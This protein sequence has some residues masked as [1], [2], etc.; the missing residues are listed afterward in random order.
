MNKRGKNSQYTYLYLLPPL[1][2]NS[3][4]NYF[5]QYSVCDLSAMRLGNAFHSIE[6]GNDHKMLS[7]GLSHRGL[8]LQFLAIH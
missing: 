1:F 4:V 2:S 3:L 7:S 5:Q 8:N 6:S